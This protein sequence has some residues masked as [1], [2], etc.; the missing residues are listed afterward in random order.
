MIALN[1]KR[2]IWKTP[3]KYENGSSIWEYSV[4][5]GIKQRCRN[6]S[7]P[8]QINPRYIGV[9]LCNEW[10]DFDNFYEW[11]SKQVGYCYLDIDGTSYHVDKDILVSGNK[12]YSPQTCVLAPQR[13]NSFFSNTESY[14]G[15]LPIGVS[16]NKAN[17]NYIAQ[18]GA[19]DYVDKYLGA[20]KTPKEAYQAFKK[21]KEYV[22][23]RLAMEY[24]GVVD[25][26]VYQA[27]MNFNVDKYCKT[28]EEY[29]DEP[30]SVL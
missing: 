10:E 25:Y 17:R 28:R 5:A 23:K 3:T 4:W 11:I 7:T 20:F 6:G 26:R 30:M 8:Q 24:A 9:M 2:S 13:I 22:A 21:T 12:V 29:L 18:C 15:N 27:L 16:Y 19:K 1:N 14:R